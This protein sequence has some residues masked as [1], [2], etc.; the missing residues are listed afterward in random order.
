MSK[1]QCD[2]CG[3]VKE[4]SYK[5]LSCGMTVST[6]GGRICRKYI[7]VCKECLQDMQDLYNGSE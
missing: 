4:C 6:V 7:Y 1:V 3:K 5:T 2:L